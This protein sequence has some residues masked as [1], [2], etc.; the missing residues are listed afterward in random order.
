M[1]RPLLSS[2]SLAF[3]EP[4]LPILS[5]GE[6]G[7]CQS[8]SCLARL[9]SSEPFYRPPSPFSRCVFFTESHPARGVT[10][11]RSSSRSKRSV[12]EQ[13]RTR[14][15]GARRFDLYEAR[16][17]RLPPVNYCLVICQN[18]PRSQECPLP[19]RSSSVIFRGLLAPVAGIQLLSL[20]SDAISLLV[21]ILPSP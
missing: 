18:P 10:A 19:M 12:G 1:I 7:R 13:Y 21:A 17:L 20:L 9:G 3:R 14:D 11:W 8:R 6:K 4:A 16:L 2:G 15:H 5:F